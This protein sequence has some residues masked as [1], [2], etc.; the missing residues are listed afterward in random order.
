MSEANIS[1]DQILDSEKET[2]ET[3]NNVKEIIDEN[4]EDEDLVNFQDQ[5]GSD[6]EEENL[7]QF[8]R[9]DDVHKSKDAS[10]F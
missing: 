3:S 8:G 5:S 7:K 6:E 10:S 1:E 9:T 2:D 4:P